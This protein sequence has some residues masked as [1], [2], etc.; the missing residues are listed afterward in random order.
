MILAFSAGAD[1][2]GIAAIISSI[3]GVTTAILGA[4]RARREAEDKANEDCRQRLKEA[5]AEGEEAMAEL[6]KL[7]MERANE[8]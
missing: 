3:A 1:L 6:H 7:K 2:L 8:E 4:R 5:R